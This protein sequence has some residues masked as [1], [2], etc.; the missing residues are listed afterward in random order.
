MRL[1][2]VWI[3]DE[4][5]G[6]WGI[7]STINPTGWQSAGWIVPLQSAWE[8]IQSATN[9]VWGYIA[10]VIPYDGEATLFFGKPEQLYYYT[11]GNNHQQKKWNEQRA[12]S[13]D[14]V[15]KSYEVLIDT[16]IKSEQ[17]RYSQLTEPQIERI[18]DQP[19]GF[20][21]GSLLFTG[22]SMAQ[23]A[24][25]YGLI[26]LLKIDKILE[27][28]GGTNTLRRE[29][30]ARSYL[31]SFDGISEDLGGYHHAAVFLLSK[32]YGI[33]PSFVADTMKPTFFM[34]EMLR[35]DPN[36]DAI[37]LS[38]RQNSLRTPEIQQAINEARARGGITSKQAEAALRVLTDKDNLDV[39][40]S[41]TTSVRTLRNTGRRRFIIVSL[42]SSL[43]LNNSEIRKFNQFLSRLVQ[44]TNKF[45]GADDPVQINDVGPP[46]RVFI[47]N[48]EAAEQVDEQPLSRF[49]SNNNL[50]QLVASATEFFNSAINE[51]T[52]DNTLTDRTIG[53][54]VIGRLG[55][56]PIN[57]NK[58]DWSKHI[59]GYGFLLKL[60]VFYFNEFL[61]R[62]V[63]TGNVPP[64]VLDVVNDIKDSRVFDYRAA[65]NMKVFRDYHYI[66]S[67]VDIVENNIGAS[68][69]EMYNAVA[70]RYSEDVD[71]S[72]EGLLDFIPFFGNDNK[73]FNSV[74]VGGS[75]EWRTWP[76]V[77]EEG[78]VGLQFNPMVTLQDKKVAVYTDLNAHRRDQL[79]KVAVNV[80]AKNMRPMYRNNL[81]ILGRPIKPWDHIFLNDKHIDMVGPLDVERVV[82]HYSPTSGW[83]TNII[84][85]A[86]CEANPGSRHVQAA[87]FQNRMDQIDNLVDYIGWAII[88]G[89]LAFGGVG[90]AA[91]GATSGSARFLLKHFLV[92]PAKLARAA[93]ATKSGAILGTSEKLGTWVGGA[94]TKDSVA[95]SFALLKSNIAKQAPQTLNTAAILGGLGI[96][97]NKISR[98]LIKNAGAGKDQLPVIFSPLIFKGVPLEAGLSGEDVLYWSL[99]SK[100]H[101]S[102]KD[103]TDGVGT[104]VDLLTSGFARNKTRL[105]R[106]LEDMEIIDFEGGIR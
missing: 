21:S 56:T 2:N 67:G 64:E 57:F 11:S 63:N 74:T 41:I 87:I 24:S 31:T 58:N 106:V 82:H 88:I 36:F 46:G 104:I 78:H 98:Y 86:V 90:G 40:A 51:T 83:C 54:S 70:V 34:K 52:I 37:E 30:D 76:S 9:Y 69:R 44:F 25:I 105:Q 92:G 101:W 60:F 3:P 81:K 8:A 1:K 13:I 20:L 94:V 80:L 103:L 32:F 23:V 55:Y 14:R 77:H 79:A 47:A 18:P 97:K 17:G 62:T 19:G 93:G 43:D 89:Q 53:D 39:A 7:L 6:R 12:V 50:D 99:A 29:V 73:D 102:W 27:A 42:Q 16:F 15:S 38:L 48:L 22:S 49:L 71:T 84:P 61:T 10:Q 65:L 91:A 35:A 72:N 85:H 68:T 96:G 75:T 4:N 5:A 59:V 66:R 100:L 33:N 28:Q 95:T 26:D 45:A